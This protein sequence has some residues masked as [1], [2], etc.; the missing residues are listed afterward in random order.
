MANKFVCEKTVPDHCIRDGIVCG[1]RER[2]MASM[3]KSIRGT[4]CGYILFEGQPRGCDAENCDK[5][6]SKEQ[7]NRS[8]D[9]HAALFGKKGLWQ[10]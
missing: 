4:M 3:D 7:A 10:R 9:S 1:Y 5:W 8:A 6:T 2:F